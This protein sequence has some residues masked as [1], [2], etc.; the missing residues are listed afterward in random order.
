MAY[1]PVFID[2][3]NKPC[4]VVGGG[5]VACRKMEVLLR[6]EADVRVVA[7]EVCEEI[8]VRL[9]ASSIRLG[10][11]TEEEIQEATLVIAATGSREVNHET[12]MLCQ[13][14]RIPVNVVDAPEECTFLFPSVVKKGD[15]SIGINT[16]AQSP[17]VSKQIRKDIEQ[18]VPDY[19]AEIAMQMGKLRA[20]LRAHVPE[21][22]QRRNILQ[23]VA[24]EVFAGEGMIPGGKI[25][26]IIRQETEK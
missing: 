6:Y 25:E 10:Q 18:A 21:E 17:L 12:V 16:G 11:V 20:Y 5:P 19:Y 24:E 2:V 26:E 22:K 3:K 1:L 14:Y 8:C 7:K 15:I 13:R 23:R 4:L 9:P